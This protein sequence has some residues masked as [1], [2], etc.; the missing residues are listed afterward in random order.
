M[1]PSGHSKNYFLSTCF[2]YNLTHTW[3]KNIDSPWMYF[4]SSISFASQYHVI[5]DM[6]NMVNLRVQYAGWY[7]VDHGLWDI[8]GTLNQCCTS[9]TP[10]SWIITFSLMLNWQY[11]L[12]G[13]DFRLVVDETACFQ[14]SHIYILYELMYVHVVFTPKHLLLICEVSN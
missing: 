1:L 11:H 14:H 5:N 13:V 8:Y 3:S 6:I 7:W 12:R 9:K 4:Q 10:S 2:R